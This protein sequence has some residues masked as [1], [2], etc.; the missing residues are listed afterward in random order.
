MILDLER[1][2]LAVVEIPLRQVCGH[3]FCAAEQRRSSQGT[4]DDDRSFA[5]DQHRSVLAKR[6]ARI[7]VIAAAGA[8]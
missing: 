6:S 5:T 8:G 7:G 2:S 1:D 3:W 4:D